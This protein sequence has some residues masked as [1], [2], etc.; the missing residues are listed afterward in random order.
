MLKES[1]IETINND[2]LNYL[3]GLNE[4]KNYKIKTGFIK[5]TIVGTNSMGKLQLKVEGELRGFDL[6][7]IEFIR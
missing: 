7:E 5:G 1:K 6:K 3:Y 2:Y 4:L